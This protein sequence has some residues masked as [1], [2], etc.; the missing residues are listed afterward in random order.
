MAGAG[1]K[2][3]TAGEILTASDTNTYLMEQTVMNFAGTASRASAIPTPSTGM[4]S[5]IGV[6]G[7]ATIPQIEVYTGSAWQTPYGLTQVAN[8]SFTS[9]ATVTLDNIFTSTYRSYKIVFGV[10]TKTT[11]S[12]VNMQ[13]R[14]AGSTLSGATT[15]RY[16]S[17]RS[18]ATTIDTYPNTTGLGFIASSTL[19]NTQSLYYDIE[20]FDPSTTTDTHFKTRWMAYDS[21]NFT[22][23]TTQGLY[24]ESGAGNCDGMIFT[25]T[26]GSVT[27]FVK[28]YGYR[29]A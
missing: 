14:R 21:V 15:Y 16:S 2:T 3:F 11:N 25:P 29:S 6:T 28:V 19:A 26:A 10:T 12:D 13:F 18:F 17:V 27:G 8:V 9:A 23:T 24:F 7:T 5:Y 1:K 20:V 22:Q 4:T